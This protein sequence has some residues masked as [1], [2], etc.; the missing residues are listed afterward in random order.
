SDT[1]TPG[2]ARSGYVAIIE[3]NAD[4]RIALRQDQTGRLTYSVRWLPSMGTLSYPRTIR[5]R[6]LS[7]PTVTSLAKSFRQYAKSAGLFR[8]LEEKIAERPL[9]GKL[10]GATACFVGYE[11]SK[12][13]Y[14]DTFRRLRA[15]GHKRFYAFPL[16]HVNCGFEGQFGGMQLIDIRDCAQELRQLGAI[17]GSWVYLAGLPE[18]PHLARLALRNADGTVPL[19]WRIGDELWLQTCMIEARQWLAGASEAIDEADAHHFD[20]TASNSLMECY[21]PTHPADRRTDR[22]ARIAIFEEVLKR[23]R[24]VASEGV[25]NWAVPYYD[26]GSNKEIPVANETPA[27]RVV[28]LQHLVYHDAIFALWWEVDTYDCPHFGGG[29]PVAQSLTDLLYGDMPLLF[30]VGRQYRWVDRGRWHAEEFEHSLELLACQEA[31]RRAVEVASNFERVATAEMTSF[32]WL[33]PDGT[34]QQTEFANG[35]SVIAN[36][37]TQLFGLASGRV[38]QPM[39]AVCL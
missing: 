3:E 2:R 26:I 33:T 10:I 16:Y 1:A 24:I 7:H 31:A 18:Q 8:S 5:Y 27:F 6:F 13:D 39:T 34:V 21:V 25:K 9:L 17:T 20:T 37:G 12:L 28:P 14:V 22:A 38:V 15:M 29:N 30:P 11:A 23:G 4:A 36:F 35:V 19:N 32:D